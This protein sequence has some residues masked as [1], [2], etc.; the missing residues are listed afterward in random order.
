VSPSGDQAISAQVILGNGC[1]RSGPTQERFA[2]LGFTVG[3]CVGTSFSIT[4]RLAQFEDAF[5]HRIRQPKSGSLEF[6]DKKGAGT[7]EL[8]GRTLPKAFS[9][10]VE[11]VTFTAPPEF[12]PT[13]W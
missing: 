7:R 11:T 9:D 10:D 8:S 6:V 12:G 5:G 13:N 2:R 3:P 4:G 1:E